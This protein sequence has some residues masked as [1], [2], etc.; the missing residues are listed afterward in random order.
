MAQAKSQRAVSNP[1]KFLWIAI[2][3]VVLVVLAIM[4]RPDGSTERADEQSPSSNARTFN[5][6]P[7][8]VGT[9]NYP[10]TQSARPTRRREL[11]STYEVAPGGSTDWMY[12]P[13]GRSWCTYPNLEVPGGEDPGM[14][15]IDANR[16]WVAG[17]IKPPVGPRWELGQQPEGQ[18]LY[19][20]MVEN[21]SE[22]F[23]LTGEIRTGPR[24]A[25]C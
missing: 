12:I 4:A 11:P 13:A 14:T 25:E 5:D 17:R 20:F 2:P 8:G 9:R 19:W 24:G 16:V 21:A 18:N 6:E 10:V 1:K 3:I 15:H 23:R 7:R 22:R